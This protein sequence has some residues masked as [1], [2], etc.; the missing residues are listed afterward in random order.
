MNKKENLQ[1]VTKLKPEDKDEN[2]SSLPF[3]YPRNN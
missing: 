2:K 3:K 1:T